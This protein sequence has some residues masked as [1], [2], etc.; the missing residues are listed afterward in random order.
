MVKWILSLV[1]EIEVRPLRMRC[2][3]GIWINAQS[4]ENVIGEYQF[5]V[6]RWY[7]NT[8]CVRGVWSG[9]LWE[10]SRRW[11]I[12]DLTWILFSPDYR[13]ISHS[14]NVSDTDWIENERDPG[15]ENKTC[16]YWLFHGIC[17]HI[18][19]KCN[20]TIPST[21]QRHMEKNELS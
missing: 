17:M 9:N 11:S 13:F 20:E 14:F 7:S 6:P 8:G 18:Q 4:E 2:L 1:N 16:I 19:Y 15:F 12:L 21:H 5:E 10:I 3:W